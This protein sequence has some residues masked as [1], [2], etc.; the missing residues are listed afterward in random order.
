MSYLPSREDASLIDVFRTWPALARPIHQFGETLMREDSPFEPGERE[1]IAAFVSTLNGCE[2]CHGAHSRAAAHFGLDPELVDQ[3]VEDIE[4]S[5]V[6]EKLKPVLHYCRKLNDRPGE[7]QRE[8]AKAVF[9]AGWNETALC[10]AALV[11]GFFNL[12]NRWV[13]GLG[14]EADP[15]IMDMAGKMLHEKGYNGISELLE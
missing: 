13:E 14:I 7:I 8:D 10:H 12:M 5:D 2:Y 3:C 9:D 11:C 4:S 15:K 1:L 6:A